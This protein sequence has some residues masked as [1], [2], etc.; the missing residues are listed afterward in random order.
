MRLGNWFGQKLQHR[1]MQRWLMGLLSLG[2][3]VAV[4]S[5]STTQVTRESVP[6]P[7]VTPVQVSKLPD[8]IEQISPTDEATTTA[9]IRIRFKQPLIAI[10]SLESDAQNELL[11]KFEVL[12]P[13]AGKFRFLTPRMV[14]FQ[15]E[16]AI[17]KATRVKV[18][19]KQGLA[20]LTNHRLEQ[21]FSWTFN[22]E[23]IKLSNLPAS[24]SPGSPDAEYAQPFELKPALKL[25]SNTELNLAALQ[26]RLSLTVANQKSSV[27]LNLALE[28]RKAETLT[29]QEQFDPA[30]REWIYV[31]EPLLPLQKGSRYQLQIAPGVTPAKGNLP[32]DAM[33]ASQI[34]TYA[35]FAFEGMKQTGKPDGSGANGRFE[36][37][38][39][40]LRF[41]NALKLESALAN[42]SI[43]PAPKKDVPLLRVY[44]GDRF[45]TLNPWALEPNTRYTIAIGDKLTDSFGQSL[46]KAATV[47][48]ETG[49]IAPD[50]WAPDG[51]NIFPVG[52][53][54]Q[55]NVSTVNLSEFKSAFQVVE[56]E[57]LVYRDSAYPEDNG[58]GLLPKL[59]NWQ[60][61]PA[62]NDRNQAVETPIPL[63]QKLGG[64]TGMLAY[65]VRA[66]TNPY[67]EDGKQKWREPT[68][69]GMVQV[70]NFGVFAQWFPQGGLVRV[71]RLA[72]GTPVSNA[73]VQVYLSKLEAKSRPTPSVC[74]TGK[75]DRTG[76]VLFSLT[77]LNRC[78]D[79]ERGFKE[80]PKLLVIAKD[81]QD[82]AFTRTLD[83]SGAYE[84]GVSAGWQDDKPLSRGVIVPDR[85]LYQPGENANFTA[86]SHSVQNG[87]LTTD[88]QATYTLTIEAPNGQRLKLPAQTT[89]QYGTFTL[90]WAIANNQPLGYYTIRAKSEA[91]VEL[92]GDFRVAEFKPPNFKVDL[93]LE[94]MANQEATDKNSLPV[95]LINQT[96]EAKAASAYLFGA[97]VEGGK[98]QYSVTRQQTEFAPKGWDSFAFGRQ[99]FY[100][101]TAP[102]VAADVLQTTRLLDT[103]GKSSQKITVDKDLPYPMVYRVDT[104]VSEASNLSVAAAKSFLALPSDKLI[105]I[106]SDF[107]GQVGKALPV[108]VIVADPKGEAI[109][110]QTVH[111]DLQQ[112]DYSRIGRLVEGSSTEETQVEYKTIA[113]AEI[114]SGQTP[115]TV[116]LTPT[117]SGSYR[118]RAT[119]PSD[120]NESTAT[121]SQIWVAGDAAVGWLDQ[122]DNNRLELKL[123]KASYKAGETATV[124]IQSP[125][126]EAELYLAVVRH[127]TIYRT[128]TQV[129]GGT[130]KVQFTVTPDMV[131][132]AAV[133]AVL[134][135]Q[136]KPVAQVEPGSLKDLTRIGFAAFT[137]NLDDRY[138]KIETQATPSLQ[139]GA[140]QVLQL[141]LSDA[142]GKPTTGQITVA[143]VNEAVLQLTG[144]RPPDLVETV[145][146]EQ[147]ISTRLSDN[148]PDVVLQQQAS[149]L[150][151]GWGY[152][153][154]FSNGAGGTRIRTDF[155]A[156]AYYNGAVQ[157]DANG[158]ATV[159]FKLPDDLTTWR[160]LLLA[161]DRNLHFGGG[162]DSTFITTQPLIAEPL[163][164]QF[165]RPGDRPAIG[166]SVINNMGQ[167]GTVAVNGSASEAIK[168]DQAATQQESLPSGSRAFR[169]PMT[170]QT[171]VAGKVKFTAS[172]NNASDG[173]EVPLEIRPHAITEQVIESGATEREVKIPLNVDRSVD[174]TVG[175]L[176]ISLASTLI[177]QITAPARQVFD[178]T[179]LP[180]LEPAASQLAIAAQLQTLAPTNGQAFDQFNPS[181]QAIQ[182]L[183]RLRKLQRSDGGFAAFP[184]QDRSDPFVTAYAARAIAQITPAFGKPAAGKPDAAALLP[185]LKDYLSKILADPG[186]YDFCKEALCK[187]QVRLEALM[188]LAELGDRRTDFVADLYAQR[189]QLD[190][191]SQIMLAR[192]L[193][194][195]PGWQGEGTQMTEKIQQKLAETG[196]SASFNLPSSWRWFHSPTTAQAETLRLFMAKKA[197]PETLDKLLQGLL[198]Q[199][200]NGTW[201][202]TY[203]NA[204]A[205]G[206]I[207]SYS[208]LQSEPP[209][210]KATAQLAGKNLVT[211]NFEG[212]R[213]PSVTTQVALADLPQ[214]QHDLVLKKTGRGV[215]HYLAAYRYRLSGAQPGRF[216]GLR[217]TRTI[218]PANQAKILYRNGLYSPDALTVAAGQVFDIEVEV[219]TDHPADHVVITDPIPAGFEAVDNSF[220]TTTAA[221]QAQSDSWQLG[222]RTIYKDKVVAFGDRLNPGVYTLHYLVRSVTPGNFAY[223]GAEAHLQYAPEDFG[224]SASFSVNVSEK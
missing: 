132:N 149:P 39:A 86:F 210:F 204:I 222:F 199:R 85:N 24:P 150:A 139:P 136:G 70:T 186:Q 215:L 118:I 172:L 83:Y 169:F 63:T 93:V 74:A 14:G 98:L 27:P 203:D 167:G 100:P 79:S 153:G 89:N 155:R 214:N 50:L 29:E 35:S 54:L 221:N 65:G 6:L 152:G 43:S 161:T 66:R 196:R 68:V 37:G 184:G 177:P 23:A 22:T 137:T 123:D 101:Q 87:K 129:K 163:L 7:A 30:L 213:R 52:K 20:D 62:I 219:I 109:A 76:T 188:A 53:D 61:T 84:Y 49:N 88:R 114:K 113:T 112:M 97:P 115:Q 212:D 58:D 142:A 111:L 126:A 28:D 138:L 1:V 104:E 224:R 48:Y 179:D 216:N 146:A 164:P 69:Y 181:Q 56:P 205:L 108:E 9:Q 8:W 55:L 148:R 170:V 77:D 117:G 72:D 135:R 143:V 182:A 32:S 197:N 40:E 18:T 201:Q 145:F 51:F 110:G 189:N 207:A 44:E 102:E 183:D 103:S 64:K 5:C 193:L 45:A 223:P 151:K 4:G 2:L 82:W 105:G 140:E 206:A 13:L 47:S 128:I 178:E 120:K 134:V 3:T 190:A 31:A 11:K 192:Y 92:T 200:R 46:G 176:E 75:S 217:V 41:N 94:G 21:D 10:A 175:G 121:D 73:T 191:V 26:Q 171:G 147:P 42:I 17:P 95:A 38:I 122:Y 60:P 71:H 157:T 166:V 180:F 91:G 159:R 119:F 99:W 162:S 107:V 59:S 36:Q 220:Q 127:N 12:P 16:Q 218:R 209:N 124:L 106:K 19:L 158:K 198:A 141:S 125:Y 133:E 78:T 165:A 174:P 57:D 96:I 116:M 211:A 208:K 67:T 15:S 34:Q 154:G 130:P 195:T 80:P 33:F 202:G 173:F 160:V 81:N 168:L 144:Y 25:T 131:P 156:L 194:Q 90:P 187:N 185:P